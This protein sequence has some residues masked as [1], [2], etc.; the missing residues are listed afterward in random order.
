MGSNQNMTIQAHDKWKTSLLSS[1]E[2]MLGTR[3]EY[4]WPVSYPVLCQELG[5]QRPGGVP[6]HLIHVAAVLH[7]V[8]TLVFVHHSEA[9]EVVRELITADWIHSTS[10]K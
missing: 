3:N 7:C 5:R 1:N 6:H 4:T 10:S 9:L 2:G 8:I